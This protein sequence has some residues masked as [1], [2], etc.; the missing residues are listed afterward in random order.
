MLKRNVW[1]L[2]KLPFNL[3]CGVELVFA[4]ECKPTNKLGHYFAMHDNVKRQNMGF[5][6]KWGLAMNLWNS[7]RIHQFTF[8]FQF[9]SN[10][11]EYIR[12]WSIFCTARKSLWKLRNQGIKCG[13]SDDRIILPFLGDFSS[14][15]SHF[16][17]IRFIF[18]RLTTHRVKGA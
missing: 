18:L 5:C 12:V 15:F 7:A 13:K 9:R 1:I 3:C 14:Y 2:Y 11:S 16:S 10:E 8:Y 4:I 6:L 17:L